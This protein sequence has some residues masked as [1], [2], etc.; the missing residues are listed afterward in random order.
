MLPF[1]SFRV[2]VYKLP[3][4]VFFGRLDFGIKI[5]RIFSLLFFE[6]FLNLSD[7]SVGFI[8]DL[9]IKFFI[10]DCGVL[11]IPRFTSH[12]RCW[13]A[14]SIQKL[15]RKTILGNK[16]TRIVSGWLCFIVNFER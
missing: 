10:L 11:R 12:Y 6:N 16:P 8:L 7:F 3:F 5:E 15:E 2:L 4:D 14:V 1:L 13:V 9:S